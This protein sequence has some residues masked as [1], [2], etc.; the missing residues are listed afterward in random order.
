MDR[1]LSRFDCGHASVSLHCVKLVGGVVVHDFWSILLPLSCIVQTAQTALYIASRKGH[2]QI[3][4]LLLRREV[5]VNHQTK[6]RSPMLVCVCSSMRSVIFFN[7]KTTCITMSKVISQ[8]PGKQIRL[9]T[10]GHNYLDSVL[11]SV[12]GQMCAQMIGSSSM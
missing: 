8:V 12:L 6:V 2:D 7:V 3:V 1:F 9:Q 5:N 4:E 11:I 10:P